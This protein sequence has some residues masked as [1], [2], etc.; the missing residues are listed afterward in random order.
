MSVFD[1]FTSLGLPNQVCKLL[2]I[3]SFLPVPEYPKM[4]AVVALLARG[5]QDEEAIPGEQ[6]KA[7]LHSPQ[8]DCFLLNRLAQRC[9]LHV[10][11]SCLLH[12]K[13]M[14]VF[15]V[16]TFLFLPKKIEE[17]SET[18]VPWNCCFYVALYSNQN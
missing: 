13:E 16:N 7:G 15:H 17:N 9:N 2:A 8:Y 6:A 5:N 1:T 3:L 18:T 12:L 14:N 11:V 4:Q 10:Q